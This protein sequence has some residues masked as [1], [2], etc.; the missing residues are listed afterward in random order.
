MWTG[1]SEVQR[2][3][4][5]RHSVQLRRLCFPAVQHIK[6]FVQQCRRPHTSFPSTF[7]PGPSDGCGECSGKFTGP[8]ACQALPLYAAAQIMRPTRPAQSE[9]RGVVSL[10]TED[11]CF[12]PPASTQLWQWRLWTGIFRGATSI[13]A[14]PLCAAA[15]PM[16]PSRSTHQGLCAAVSPASHLLSFHLHASTERWLW[17]MI[18]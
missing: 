2:Q 11:H 18:G 15:L 12:V 14:P 13:P 17:G 5:P 6:G 8:A 3:S 10:A 4:R 16:L 1:N 7:T 9:L